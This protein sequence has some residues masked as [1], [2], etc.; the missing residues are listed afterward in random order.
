MR[1]CVTMQNERNW[2]HKFIL[3]K[4]ME[5]IATAELCGMTETAELCKT[6]ETAELCGTLYKLWNYAK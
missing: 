3:A 4:T 5:T 6:I 2:G 1:N